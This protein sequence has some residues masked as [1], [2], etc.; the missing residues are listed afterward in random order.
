MN[1]FEYAG[2]ARKVGLITRGQATSDGAGVKMHRLLANHELDMLDPF[3]LFDHFESD[4]PG[5]YIGGFPSHPHRG[6]ETVTYMLAGKMRHKDSAGN[7][8]V[9]GPN[10]VQWMTAGSGIIHSEMPEQEQGLMSGFQL[11]VNLPAEHKRAAP[12]YQEFESQQ[13]PVEESDDGTYI[14]VIAGSSDG[15]TDG[16]VQNQFV[17]PLYLH[18][19]LPPNTAIT[20]ALEPTHNAFI[21]V[22]K[23]AIDVAGQQ[24][25]QKQLAVL[26]AS[27]END[28]FAASTSDQAAE[29]L[30]IAAQPLNEP[31]ARHGP[32]VMNTADEIRQAVDDY[33]NGR[34]VR[35]A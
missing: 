29:L 28:H 7:E 23:G 2:N 17:H 27:P 19:S 18:I 3:L 21:F 15:G 12:A 10:G 14:R 20:Q 8:G 35:Q 13:L 6:F 30:L 16:A 33:N 31:V 11:W 26:E 25:E 24:I 34:L 32:F 4:Q 1:K 22:I 9:I 5:D